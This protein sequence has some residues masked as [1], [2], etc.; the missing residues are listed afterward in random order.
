MA[1]ISGWSASSDDRLLLRAEIIMAATLGII[2]LRATSGLEPLGSATSDD[3]AGPIEDMV[4]A[5]LSTGS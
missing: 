2:Q 1:A 5:L 4:V 3:L